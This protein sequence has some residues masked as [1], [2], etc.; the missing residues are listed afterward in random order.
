MPGNSSPAAWSRASTTRPSSPCE[1][2]TDSGPSASLISP[3]T[4]PSAICRSPT[5]PT[6]STDEPFFN[7]DAVT[8][9]KSGQR[10]AAS[11]N[12]PLVQCQ[13]DL[14]QCEVRLLAV[15]R[16]DLLG[17]LLQ[18]RSASAAR[19]RFASPVL[20]KPLHPPDGRT[21]ADVEL[22]SRL[23]AGTSCF[24]KADDPPS[25]FTR[26]RST[27]WLVPRESMR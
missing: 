8:S 3:S 12:S 26:I 11:S 25:Q 13:D 23:T 9:E 19:H 17:V 27:H 14:I 10:A 7:S 6:D 18:W 24:N 1:K 4:M 20:A 2:L 21:D 5:P 22:F 16:K 15:E